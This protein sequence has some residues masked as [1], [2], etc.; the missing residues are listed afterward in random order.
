MEETERNSTVAENAES[1]LESLQERKA[2]P[3]ARVVRAEIQEK[4]SETESMP[5]KVQGTKT[6]GGSLQLSSGQM[7]QLIRSGKQELGN[8]R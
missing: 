2:L 8:I 6:G 1:R 7:R 3:V 5:S 4:S